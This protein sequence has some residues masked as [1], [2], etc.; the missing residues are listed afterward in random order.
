MIDY[1]RAHVA[2]DSEADEIVTKAK[3]FH[4]LVETWIESKFARLKR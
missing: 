4:E 3:E 2:T 1:T